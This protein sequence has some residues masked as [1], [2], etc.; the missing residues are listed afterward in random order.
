MTWT[1]AFAF[2][3]ILGVTATGLPTGTSA[4]PDVAF[5]IYGT[6]DGVLSIYS[7]TGRFV[8]TDVSG[9]IFDV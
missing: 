9:M 5:T 2:P 6:F 4:F 1:A 8:W 7:S 3:D